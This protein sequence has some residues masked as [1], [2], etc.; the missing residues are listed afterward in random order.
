LGDKYVIFP[1]FVKHDPLTTEYTENWEEFSK[2]LSDQFNCIFD[3]VYNILLLDPK[4]HLTIPDPKDSKI[5]LPYF[6]AWSGDQNFRQHSFTRSAHLPTFRGDLYNSA[7][8]KPGEINP[9]KTAKANLADLKANVI[10]NGPFKMKLTNDPSL[11]LRFDET[12]CQRPTLLLLDSRT[13]KMLALLD[14][15]GFMA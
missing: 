15:T 10:L 13:I 5:R 1:P 9:K 14:L 7:G 6:R 4:K 11:H 12:D 8:I 3:E 2:R